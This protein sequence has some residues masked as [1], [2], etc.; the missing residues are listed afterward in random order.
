MIGSDQRSAALTGAAGTDLQGLGADPA[1]LRLLKQRKRPLR[2]IHPASRSSVLSNAVFG[3]S[4]R[5]AVV[6][7]NIFCASTLSTPMAYA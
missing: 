3:L 7:G 6:L 4:K 2:L 1:S 5:T